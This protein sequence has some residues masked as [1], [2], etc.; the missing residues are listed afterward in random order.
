MSLDPP[1]SADELLGHV[2]ARGRAIQREE[3]RRRI[4]TALA[5]AVVVLLLG[6]GAALR[7]QGPGGGSSD[8]RTALGSNGST[9]TSA[10]LL[11]SPSSTLPPPDLSGTG[12]PS[13]TEGTTSSTRP[14]TT[15][16]APRIVPTAVF[17]MRDPDGRYRTAVLRKGAS[18][19]VA[20]TAATSERQWPVLSP[21]GTRIAFAST[22]HNLLEKVRPIWELY[23]INVD[24]SGLRQITMTPLDAGNGTRWPSW[25][26][27]GKQ[28]VAACAT[29]TATPSI[30]SLRPDAPGIRELAA[31]DYGLIWPRWSPDGSAI[32]ALHKESSS[33]V[34]AWIVDP[35]GTKA[36]HRTPGAVLSFDGSSPPNWMPGQP[37]LLIDQA[38]GPQLLDVATGGL[39]KLGLPGSDFVACGRSQVLYRTAIP[40]G[41]AKVG[42]LVLVGIDG[43]MPTVVLP[44]RA[45]ADLIPTG[46]A[47]R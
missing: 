39:T 24:G 19:P 3:Q 34:S 37:Q 1:R 13:G 29:G 9:S 28:I 46:C 15:T 10:P 35:T 18:D 31:A 16:T 5:P 14:S 33:T 8:V 41:P 42:D 12:A 2:L 23:V 26:P 47:I 43:S 4:L 38:I 40:Y 11:G 6:L 25:S 27:D 7:P 17:E 20:I 36:P 30:C 44:K 45:A 32:V 21:D 22:Q